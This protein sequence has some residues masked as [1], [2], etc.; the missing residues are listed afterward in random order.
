MSLDE[1]IDALKAKH[2]ALEAALDEENNRPR[3]DEM[4]IANLKKRK[5]RIKDEIASLSR[6]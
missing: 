2:Q 4:H 1:R 3:P 6:K 5:L